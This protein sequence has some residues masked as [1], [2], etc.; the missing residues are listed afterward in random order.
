MEAMAKGMERKVEELRVES[1]AKPP[2]D[3][4]EPREVCAGGF[5]GS[6]KNVASPLEGTGKNACSPLKKG[7]LVIRDPERETA[8]F[9]FLI[10]TYPPD[11]SMA[12]RAIRCVELK[13]H[14]TGVAKKPLYYWCVHKRDVEKAHEF[15]DK[16]WA[17]TVGEDT[18]KPEL[19]EHEFNAG[20]HL[21]CTSACGGMKKVY[22][23]IFFDEEKKKDLTGLF[24]MDSDVLLLRPELW[25]NPF[26]DSLADYV[27]IPQSPVPQ[28][29]TEENPLVCGEEL[30]ERQHLGCGACYLLSG[31]A[32]HVI[33]NHPA[34]KFVQICERNHGAEDRVF[35]IVLQDAK[36]LITSEISPRHFIGKSFEKDADAKT[37][38][39]LDNC[40]DNFG[41]TRYSWNCREFSNNE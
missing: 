4:A 25:T 6:D 3:S 12:A 15:L 38:I 35:G 26:F 29:A 17:K 14:R 23:D 8:Q 7:R 9:G 40:K 5:Q 30:A 37:V 41:K 13:W 1:A 39:I 28:H 11:Y 34:K 16:E 31:Y 10:F 21:Q 18:P 24:K 20:G 19:I 32:A 33:G 36:C 2:V 22:W 27:Y